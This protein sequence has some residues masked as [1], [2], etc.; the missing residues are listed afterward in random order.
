MSLV[1]PNIIAEALGIT[2]N[3]LRKRRVSGN[4][5]DNLDYIVTSSGRALYKYDS[6]PPDDRV[7]VDK[8]TIRRK[9]QAH[10]DRMKND[11]RYANSLGKYNA[12]RKALIQ[13]EIDKKAK[14]LFEKEKIAKLKLN[15]NR[16]GSRDN[17]KENNYVKWVDAKLKGVFTFHRLRHQ[18]ATDLAESNWSIA[19][20]SAQGGWRS[21][22]SLQRYTHIQA[23][24]LAKKMKERG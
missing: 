14:E 9:R 24:H 11:F 8:I 16:S 19:E 3:A 15:E 4:N 7:I 13:K 22:S 21:L 6:I 5:K 2:S 12:R 20:L 17:W 23:K 18:G 10:D 1:Q